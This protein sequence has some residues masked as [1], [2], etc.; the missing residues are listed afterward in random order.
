MAGFREIEQGIRRGCYAAGF[1][2]YGAAPAFD[3]ALCVRETTDFPLIWFG[4]FGE[5]VETDLPEGTEHG[6]SPDWRGELDFDRYALILSRLREYLRSGDTYQTNYTMRLRSA[7]RDDPWN[8]FLSL[9]RNSGA[10][11]GAF[12]RTGRFSIASA[13]PE[14]F[15]SREGNT[16]VSR[17]MKGTRRR[18]RTLAEDLAFRDALTRSEKDRAENIMIVDMI[19]NDMGRIAN[20]GSVRVD[21]LFTAEKYPTVWQM[22][23]TVSCKTGAPLTEIF[24]ALFPCASVTGAPK[25]RTM[26]IIR[27]LEISPRKIYTGAAGFV[28]PGNRAQF[29]VAIRTALIDRETGMAEYGVGGGIVWD[30]DPESEYRECLAKAAVLRPAPRPFELLETLRW[31]PEEGVFLK[32]QHIRRICRSAAYFDFPVSECSVRGVLDGLAADLMAAEPR[33]AS[34]IRLLMDS[35]GRLR[36]EVYPLD[37]QETPAPL[38]LGLAQTPVNPDDPFLYHKTTHRAVYEEAARQR[39]DCDDV[40]LWNGRGEIT[41]TTRFNLVV[42]EEGGRVTPPVDSGLLAGTFREFLLE[43]GE[44]R[45]KILTRENLEGARRLWCINSVRGRV[46]AVLAPE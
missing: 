11:Y 41:E 3:A 29:N 12:I 22:T 6:D 27:E 10:G 25:P 46:P 19:R 33:A 42:E 32:E 5:A 24:R 37:V 20:P 21:G 17:P 8:F 34:L 13:S 36:T 16:L 40:I 43:R 44:I 28:T 45:E 30:S 14:L 18:G 39:P 31:T 26:E 9:I 15:F 2:S 4:L 38:R 1:V 7:F 23:S 35:A